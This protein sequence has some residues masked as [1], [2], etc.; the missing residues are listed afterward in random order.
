M[1]LSK[2]P[3]IFRAQKSAKEK[4]KKN[5]MNLSK[6]PIIFRAQKSAQIR[7]ICALV[8]ICFLKGTHILYKVTLEMNLRKIPIIFVTIFRVQ[9]S[10]QNRLHKVHINKT[11][12]NHKSQ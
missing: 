8:Y 12:Q 7:Y 2:I 10:V 9:K 4:R 6:I 5:E 1:N 11:K 3:I